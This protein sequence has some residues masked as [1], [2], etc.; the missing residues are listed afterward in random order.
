MTEEWAK[1]F[2]G[3]RGGEKLS[4]LKTSGNKDEGRGFTCMHKLK[5]KPETGGLAQA[6]AGRPRVGAW[7]RRALR[8]GVHDESC[9]YLEARLTGPVSPT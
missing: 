4:G 9:P 7:L 8:G 6:A 1:A 2:Q 5:G 3:R